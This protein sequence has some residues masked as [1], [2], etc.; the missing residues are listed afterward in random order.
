[1]GKKKKCV[2]PQSYAKCR[3]Q[4]NAIQKDKIQLFTSSHSASEIFISQGYVREREQERE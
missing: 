3:I 4:I 1:M 2:V